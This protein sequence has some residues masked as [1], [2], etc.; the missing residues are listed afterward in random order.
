MI[1]SIQ[2]QKKCYSQRKDAFSNEYLEF[3]KKDILNSPY[4]AAS[5][6]SD[7]F[8]ETQGFSV[9]FKRSTIAEVEKKLPYFKPYLDTALKS[10]C[11]AFYLNPLIL[12]SDTYVEPHVDC[13]ISEYGMEMVMPNL[14]SVLYVQ[15]PSDLK[16]GELVLQQSEEQVWQIT[17]QINTL[18]YFLGWI[19]HSVNRVE[20]SHKRISLICEQYNLSESR[21][22]KI[23]DFEIKSGKDSGK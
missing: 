18:L 3:L 19:T 8:V 4:L 9:V 10:S 14:V 20:S 6:L 21:L 1:S 16:G 5:Q 11:N 22:N 7:G 23:P 2:T 12:N 13:S 15:V 17:P